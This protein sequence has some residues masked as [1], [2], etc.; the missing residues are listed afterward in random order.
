MRPMETARDYAVTFLFSFSAS[1]GCVCC[2][3]QYAASCEQRA[4]DDQNVFCRPPHLQL[5]PAMMW[6]SYALGIFGDL[7][8]CW[9]S[10][11]WIVVP[12]MRRI[13]R[14][15]FARAKGHADE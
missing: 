5:A 13:A 4:Y 9:A 8:V 10:W 14:E 15:E 6:R 12:A 3:A 2:N 1:I 7:L 11:R